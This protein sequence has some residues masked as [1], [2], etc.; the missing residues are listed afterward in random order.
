MFKALQSCRLC[1]LH[2]ARHCDSEAANELLRWP[3]ALKQFDIEPSD[4]YEDTI[5]L[6]RA[7]NLQSS[8]LERVSVSGYP[9]HLGIEESIPD[10]ARFCSLTHISFVYRNVFSTCSKTAAISVPCDVLV[11]LEIDMENEADF[12]EGHIGFNEEHAE[13]IW[14]FAHRYRSINPFGSLEKI[15]ILYSVLNNTEEIAFEEDGDLSTSACLEAW[16]LS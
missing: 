9:H 1:E 3:K 10:L 8:R 14:D 4:M 16:G 12:M 15:E 7:L 6:Q 2:F 11:S 13:W 5:H